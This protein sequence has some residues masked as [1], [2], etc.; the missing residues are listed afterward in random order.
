MRRAKLIFKQIFPIKT[1]CDGPNFRRLPRTCSGFYQPSSGSFLSNKKGENWL[2]MIL[3]QR[4]NQA[5]RTNTKIQQYRLGL[6]LPTHNVMIQYDHLEPLKSK[7]FVWSL[8]SIIFNFITCLD[9]VT[10]GHFC[11]YLFFLIRFQWD[12]K[13]PE[14]RT[15]S[16]SGL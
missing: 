3:L 10:V 6:S 2:M 7:C 5:E 14:F 1:F 11:F 15:W 12:R 8:Y 16:G 4:W 9:I 13:G